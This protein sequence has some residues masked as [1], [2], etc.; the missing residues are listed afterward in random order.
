MSFPKKHSVIAQTTFVFG[1]A[2]LILSVSSQMAEAQIEWTNVII[3]PGNTNP[4]E[5]HCKTLGDFDGDGFLDA[6]AASA[7]GEGLHWYH[8]PS[9]TKYAIRA[10]GT[11]S[12]DMQ[13]GDVDGDGDMDIVIPKRSSGSSAVFWYENPRPDGDPRTDPWTEHSI[14]N[15]GGNGAHDLELADFNNDGKLDVVV[16]ERA[17][18]FFQVTPTSWTGVTIDSGGEG[19]AFGDIDGDNDLDIARHGYWMRNPLPG[20]DPKLAS[21][22]RY[23]IDSGWPELV[24]VHIRDINQ[25][26]KMDVLLAPSESNNGSLSWYETSDPINGTWVEHEIDS[27][28]HK[29]H[30][31]KT[32]DVNL[33]GTLDVII[34][35]MH[36]TSTGRVAVYFNDTGDALSW[37]RQVIATTGSHNIRVQDIDADGDLDIFGANWND[38]S[39]TSAAIE[40]WRNDLTLSLDNW[41]R[42]AIDDLPQRA[43]FVEAADLDGDGD[44]DLIAGAWWWKNPG[45]LDGTW[46]RQAIG[47]SLNNHA[48]VYDFDQDGDF[49][50]LGTQGVGSASNH[51]Y[52]WAENNG[53]GAFTVRTNIDTGGSGDFIQGRVIAD[54]GSGPQVALSWHNGG[55]GVQALGLPA[56]PKTD[57]WPFAT[58]SSTTLKEDLSAGD[59]DRDGDQDLLLGTKWLENTSSGWVAHTLGS[60]SDLDSDAEPDRSDLADVNNDGRLDAVIALENGTDVLWF[61]APVDPKDTW[62]RHAIG[63]VSGQG[64]SMDTRDFD[65]DGDPDVVVGEHRGTTLNR[66]I[67]FENVNEGSSWVVHEIDSDSSS[68]IDH[69]DGTQAVDLDNDGDLDL[70][71]IGWTN[72]KLWIYENK[73]IDGGVAGNR[74]PI[75]SFTASLEVGELPVEVDLNA[76]A[77]IDPDGDPLVYTWNFGD[78]SDPGNGITLSHTYTTAGSYT[79]RLTVNDGH[80]GVVSTT[81]QITVNEVDVTPPSLSLIKALG[82]P[83][84]VRVVFSEPV[85]S[86]TAEN[87][88]NYNIDQG[89]SIS[90]AQL[91][92][93]GKTAL[94]TTSTLS[95]GINYTLAVINVQDRANSP[96]TILP[97]SQQSFTFSSV[98]STLKLWLKLDEANGSAASDSSANDNGGTL[99]G[100]ASFVPDGKVDGAVDVDG[101]TGGVELGGLDVSGSALTIALWFRADDFGTSDG[102]LISK[103][104]GRQAADHYWM[105]STIS[106]GGT[107]LRFRLKTNG[108]TNTLIAGS[109][110]VS[111]GTWV[112]ATAVYDG[113]EMRL[114]QDGA[115]V[116]SLAKS[117]VI[118]VDAS[119]EAAIG[120][121]PASALDNHI[122]PFDGRIDDVRIYER[123]LS[124]TE[125]Q[126]IMNESEPVSPFQQW[127]ID[128]G[129]N[130]DALANSDD[131]FDGFALLVEYALGLDPMISDGFSIVT[132]IFDSS[133]STFSLTYPRV[134][135]DVSYS[136]EASQDL[137]GWITNGVNQ[138]SGSVGQEVT[139][140]I[141]TA[142]QPRGFLRLRISLP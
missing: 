95:E 123:V 141:G 54:F 119:V 138:G 65:R 43:I 69:H 112:H 82:N 76:S 61:E 108:T 129:I 22:T 15:N 133:Q 111:A 34:A 28:V 102:R 109:G 52:A 24:G 83:N 98:D 57:Q 50:I 9:W 10:G 96:N 25:D 71:S 60:I 6:T 70:I 110:G 31:F 4:K 86:A 101:A 79:L 17:K 73:A 11:Y 77:T 26:G 23:E 91:Q 27:P 51:N 103:A 36:Q 64:F 46:T 1:L 121:Q 47:S 139:A 105:L 89:I 94:L 93:D 66:V 81:R 87:I 142:G 56:A 18:I 107:K 35:E 113:S 78:G 49:D 68:V 127:K 84:Q 122:K 53:S 7:A 131:D 120:R 29:I 16:G 92:T 45:S 44:K 13:S 39:S 3:D 80:G 136:V 99:T 42:H 125:I 130:P 19:I 88:A 12:T 114:Y 14:G 72:P 59:I 106:S 134:R 63:T 116:G 48:L 104:T 62:T 126:A 135:E 30:T 20:G 117:G 37:T 90:E 58:L 128:Q 5:P 8:Y 38:G 100:G 2:G 140:S 137:V 97:G 67:I 33:D 74:A 115:L 85:E 132:A 41:E 75:P 40:Y 118:S 124:L 32:G 55:G 21:W